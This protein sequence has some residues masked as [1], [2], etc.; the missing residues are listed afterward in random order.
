M[1]IEVLTK[2]QTIFFFD[3]IT[4]FYCQIYIND[5]KITKFVLTNKKVMMN[6][7]TS[8]D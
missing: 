1:N 8:V 5:H 7:D 2:D 6:M 4:V 3:M